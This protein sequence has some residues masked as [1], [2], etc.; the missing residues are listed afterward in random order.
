MKRQMRGS[1]TMKYFETVIHSTPAS[2]IMTL[3]D[4]IILI[5]HSKTPVYLEHVENT[6]QKIPKDTRFNL[7]FTLIE[8]K[9][10]TCK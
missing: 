9:N 8:T 4:K 6:V 7:N 5:L 1:S 10:K 3:K 2:V